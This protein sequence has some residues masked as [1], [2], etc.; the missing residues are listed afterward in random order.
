[1]LCAVLFGL[2]KGY[3]YDSDSGLLTIPNANGSKFGFGFC[4]QDGNPTVCHKSWWPDGSIKEH[5][6]FQYRSWQS[7]FADERAL[8]EEGTSYRDDGT[9][10]MYACVKAKGDGELRRWHSNGVDSFH[11]TTRNGNIHG[12]MRVWYS[13][14]KIRRE[15]NFNNRKE[16]GRFRWFNQ[17]GGILAECFCEDGKVIDGDFIDWHGDVFEDPPDGQELQIQFRDTY[18]NRQHLRQQIWN[19]QGELIGEGESRDGQEW[20]GIFSNVSGDR[21]SDPIKELTIWENGVEIAQIPFDPDASSEETRSLIAD[22]RM[23]AVPQSV[24]DSGAE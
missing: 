24:T 12:L 6:F 2:F 9:R 1:M 19:R 20:V 15:A 11:S 16:E 8:Q 4:Y 13:S 18:R 17:T 23:N 10:E 7:L 21:I 22:M 3:R 5:V 14:G